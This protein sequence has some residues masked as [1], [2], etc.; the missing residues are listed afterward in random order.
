[1]LR[2]IVEKAT[3]QQS[4]K[5]KLSSSPFFWCLDFPLSF[6]FLLF[7]LILKEKIMSELGSLIKEDKLRNICRYYDIYLKS[8]LEKLDRSPVVPTHLDKVNWAVQLNLG[9][10]LSSFFL[11]LIW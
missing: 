1:L 7:H 2:H 4:P 3:Q 5:G 6:S 8:V 9:I 11:F 10:F